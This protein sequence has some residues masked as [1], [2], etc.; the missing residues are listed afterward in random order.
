LSGRA[1]AQRPDDEADILDDGVDDLLG[2]DEAVD[3]E[4]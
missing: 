3:E 1:P 4:A 2:E